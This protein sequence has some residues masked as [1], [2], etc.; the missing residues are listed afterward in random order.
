MNNKIL[1]YLD[2]DSVQD[3]IFSSNR[4]RM[5]TGASSLLDDINRRQTLELWKNHNSNNNPHSDANFIH[6]SGG[7]TKLLFD[8]EKKANDF[9][10]DLKKVYHENGVSVTIHCETVT[11]GDEKAALQK[12]EAAM[13][14]KKYQ[15]YNH[16]TRPAAPFI[17]YCQECCRKPAAVLLQPTSVRPG[18]NKTMEPCEDCLRKWQAGTGKVPLFSDYNF[19][20]EIAKI[21]GNDAKSFVALVALDGNAMGKKISRLNNFAD[22][23]GFSTATEEVL[24]SSLLSTMTKFFPP[25]CSNNI[26]GFRPLICGGDDIMFI[27]KADMALEYTLELIDNI[28]NKSSETEL[29]NYEPL[30]MSAG[31]IFMKQK[32]PFAIAARL[33]SSLLSSAKMKSRKNSDRAAIDYHI[34]SSGASENIK[35]LRLQEGLEKRDFDGSLFALSNRPYTTTEIQQLIQKGKALSGYLGSGTRVQ[36]LRKYFNQGRDYAT[37]MMYKAAAR[38]N[39]NQQNGFRKDFIENGNLWKEHTSRSLW[40]T[41][42]LDIIELTGLAE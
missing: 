20:L 6:S 5:I 31:V 28:R 22:L 14:R 18:D 35:D 37:I 1:F 41:E 15:K 3:F 2:I 24:Q 38:L 19:D 7:Q 26:K 16:H 29:L 42:L 17:K 10:R 9:G 11:N 21:A 27:C 13:A 23:K 40:I 32:Y 25:D 30:H 33:V 36:N 34:V 39:D 8:S 4:L 12:A